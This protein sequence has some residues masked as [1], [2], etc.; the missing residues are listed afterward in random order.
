[1]DDQAA[2]VYFSLFVSIFVAKVT[3]VLPLL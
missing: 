3:E 2:L 1:L